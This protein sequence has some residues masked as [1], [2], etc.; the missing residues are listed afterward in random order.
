GIG[1]VDAFVI[2]FVQIGVVSGGHRRLPIMPAVNPRRGPAVPL[3]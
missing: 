3:R 2:G 1:V